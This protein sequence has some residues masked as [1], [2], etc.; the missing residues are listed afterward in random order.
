MALPRRFRE[1]SFVLLG[2]G[3]GIEG[4]DEFRLHLRH[5]GQLLIG[6]HLIF[7]LH[8]TYL[9]ES[10]APFFEPFL[11][12]PSHAFMFLYLPPWQWQNLAC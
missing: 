2:A 5:F 1:P 6:I 3:R 4:K 12:S 11:S 8:H 10:F 9:P 7:Y